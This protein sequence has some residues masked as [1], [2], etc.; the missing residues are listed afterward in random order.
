MIESNKFYG[1]YRG[2]VTDNQDELN[3]GRIKISCPDALGD[4][5][6]GWATPCV[7]YAGDG[8][9]LFL[10]PPVG[11]HVWVEFER[12]NLDYPIWSGCFWDEGEAPESDPN[13]KLLKT[14]AGTIRIDDSNSQGAITIETDGGMKITLDTDGITITN[15]LDATIEFSGPTVSIN[16][17]ALEVT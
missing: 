1:K 8:V 5:K 12:G 11:A 15:G 17:Q 3:R 2:T 10:I 13:I 14:S 9:G 7:P 6:S 16:N 4:Q